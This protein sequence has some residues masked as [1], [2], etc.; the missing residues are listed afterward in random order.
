MKI[1]RISV[2]SA[3]ASLNSGARGLASAEAARRLAEYGENRLEKIAREPLWLRC[4]KQ[5]TSFFALI[6]W[7]AAG[8]AFVAEWRDPGTGMALLGAAIVV[9]ILINGTFSFWQEYRA[10]RAIAALARLLPSHATV[11]R[12]GVAVQLA[13]EQLVPGDIVLLQEGD[14]I[15]AD[16]RVIESH[17]LRVNEATVTGEAAAS[18]K[19]PREAASDD[20]LASR[21]VVL[22]GTLAVAGSAQALVFATGMRT[23]FGRIARLTQVATEP[24]SPLQLEISRLSRLVAALAALL[25][26]IF[27]ALGWALGMPFWTNFIFAIG[28]I[29]ANVPEGLLPT[30]TLALAMATQRMAKRNALIRHLP[31]VE[32]LGSTTVICTDKTGTL[33]QN[34]MHVKRLFFA[35]GACDYDAA[36]FAAEPGFARRRLFEVA[37][38]CHALRTVAVEGDTQ[39]LGDPMEVTLLEMGRALAGGERDHPRRD[40]IAFDSDRKRFS[41]LHDTPAGG[42]LYCKGALE[43][44]LPLCVA[45]ETHGRESALTAGERERVRAAESAFAHDGMRVLAFAFRALPAGSPRGQW[46]TQLT[47]AGLVGLAD[48]VRPEVP[49]AIRT[50]RA[51]GIRVIMVTGDHPQT[52]LAVAREIGLAQLPRPRVI[53]GD[54]LARLTDAQLQ[55]ALDAPDLIFARVGANQKMVIVDALQRKNHIVAATGDGVNDAPALKRADIG[56]AMGIIG[57]DVAKEAAD[58]ILLDDNFASI[59][60]AIEEGRAVFDNIRKFLTYILTSNIPELV[61]YL[62]FALARIPLPLTIMQIL[63]VDLGT[64]MLPA[65]ALGA[66]QPAPGGMARP[67]RPRGERLLA[68]PLLARAYLFLG[69]LEAAAA[70][71]AFFFVLARGGW[72]YGEPLAAADPLYLA[73]TAAC[74][75]AIVAMQVVNV[76]LCRHASRSAF[77]FGLLSNPLMLWGIAFEVGLAA[78]IIYTPLGNEVF[79]TAPLDAGVWLFVL[80]FALAMLLAEEARKW[81]VRYRAARYQHPERSRSS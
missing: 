22:A 45:F 21:N 68:W 73:A 5:F 7:V 13:S 41:T 23:E 27:F 3:L 61:P 2:E 14:R 28:V 43:S 19:D 70:M 71:A 74:F 36:R 51:A 25:G 33:T 72:H 69:V 38:H 17:G 75:G 78:V 9:V 42:V 37:R 26:L 47:L 48:P 15:S 20:L 18:D 81:V 32:T 62:A 56:I 40:E 1:N 29:V 35:D 52:A 60:A 59:V 10:E 80:P 58:M 12:D 67:P 49:A 66:E 76:F 4:L 16:C 39:L 57:T 46:E 63:A 34:R 11:L 77:D 64:D 31:A 79:G 30:V 6:L 65:L 55:V 50:S 54:E 24:L 44:V 8:L 53:T